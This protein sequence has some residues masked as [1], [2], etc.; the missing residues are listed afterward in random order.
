LPAATQKREIRT[1][2]SGKR[3]A[4]AGHFGSGW[5]ISISTSAH[6]R[7]T[8][9]VA[10]EAAFF[11]ASARASSMF[12]D[13]QAAS[14]SCNPSGTASGAMS[15]VPSAWIASGYANSLDPPLTMQITTRNWA[16]P[17]LNSPT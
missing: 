3:S 2:V 6:L 1:N 15:G 12:P 16:A 11:A 8:S 10:G 13:D 14:A 4:I 17:G 9:D 5:V 7:T